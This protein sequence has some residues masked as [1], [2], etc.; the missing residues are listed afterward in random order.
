MKNY[1]NE[2]NLFSSYELMAINE[3]QK[4]IFYLV[5]CSYAIS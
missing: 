5:K 4:S 2:N 3:I 1:H